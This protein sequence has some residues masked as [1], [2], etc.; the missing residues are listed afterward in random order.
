MNFVSE[1]EM[2]MAESGHTG[3]LS[4]AVPPMALHLNG[5][6]CCQKQVLSLPS[7]AGGS[8][9]KAA[10]KADQLMKLAQFHT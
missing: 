1:V 8:Y 2:V 4:L 7:K 5:F 3:T 9:E 10:G 6:I